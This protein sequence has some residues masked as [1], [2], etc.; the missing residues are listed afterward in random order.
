MVV[1]HWVTDLFLRVMHGENFTSAEDAFRE[2]FSIIENKLAFG[3]SCSSDM[4][5][6]D[7]P[8]EPNF[9]TQSYRSA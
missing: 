5:L 1:E 3:D 2:G 8:F 6:Q 4:W 7:L 9:V